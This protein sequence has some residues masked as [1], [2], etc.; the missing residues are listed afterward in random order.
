MIPLQVQLDPVSTKPGEG[1]S[2]HR[3]EELRNGFDRDSWVASNGQPL[4]V[5][6]VTPGEV[7][8]AQWVEAG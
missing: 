2:R 3:S 8:Q 5:P 1:Q 4:R 7:Q 6:H